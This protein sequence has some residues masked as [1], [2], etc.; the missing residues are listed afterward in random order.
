MKETKIERP[1]VLILFCWIFLAVSVFFI[2]RMMVDNERLGMKY[3]N[4]VANQNRISIVKQVRGNWQTLDGIATCIGNMDAVDINALQPTIREIN[5]KNEF[6]RMG[7]LEP[8]GKTDLI[9]VDGNIY[10]NVD[11]SQEDFF[12]RALAG[13]F[14]V[15]DTKKDPFSDG[16]INYYGVPIKKDKQIIGVLCAVNGTSVLRNI[17]DASLFGGDGFSNIV[18]ATGDYTV[19]SSHTGAEDTLNIKD[20]GTIKDDDLNKVLSNMAAGKSGFFKFNGR[21]AVKWGSYV[22]IGINDWYIVSVA[23]KHSFDQNYTG[24]IWGIITIVIAAL[25]MF[26]CLFYRM[27]SLTAK[28]KKM[29]E[30][31]AYTDELTGYSSYAKFLIDAQVELDKANEHQYILWYCDIKNFKYLNDLFGYD[32]GDRV[33]CY[34]AD[35]LHAGLGPKEILCHVSADNF[36][37]LFV[38]RDIDQIQ[39]WFAALVNKLENHEAIKSYDYRIEISMG[40]YRVEPQ[41]QGVSLK[42]LVNRANMAKKTAKQD[43]GSRCI[44]YSETTHQQILKETAIEAKMQK[45]LDA[46][47]FECY[48]HPKVDIQ[49][50]NLIVGA[51]VLARWNDAS[52]TTIFPGEFIPLFEKNGFIVQLDRYMFQRICK[53]FQNYLS[54][55]NKSLQISINVSRLALLQ[56]DFIDFYVGVKQAFCIPD[57]L[58]ELEFTESVA[59]NDTES[60]QHTIHELKENGFVCSLDDFGAGYSSLNVLKDLPIDVLKMDML[61]FRKGTSNERERI[62]IRNIVAMARD[63]KM[64]TVAEGVERKEQVEFLRQTGCDVVQGYVFSKPMPI[65][66]FE[67]LLR[68]NSRRIDLE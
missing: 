62:V 32:K 24:T 14:S 5:D 1:Y 23:S 36:V 56:D 58:L 16:Y 55:G 31:L 51:E 49:R 66:K 40:V 53:W 12:K 57:G 13:A 54:Q 21:G 3:L 8:H 26:T 60:F 25:L 19:R 10:R 4:D 48:L 38:D 43:S 63:L 7:I 52:G 42:D 45:A 33:L 35:T 39:S 27:N 64:K 34:T 28:N 44:F 37:G 2:Y 20:L 17:V 47:E 67:A 9:D 15:S 68:K 65:E 6:I 29:L 18:K 61:F 50:G 41:D 46:G 59:L 11:L 22:P 30:D